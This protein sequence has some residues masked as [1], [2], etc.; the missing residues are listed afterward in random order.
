MKK[1]FLIT[2]LIS[3][4]LVTTACTY[5]FADPFPA[6]KYDLVSVTN[7][8]SEPGLSVVLEEKLRLAGGFSPGSDARLYVTATRFTQQVETVSSTG[9]PVRQKLTLDVA[10]EVEGSH[11]SEAVFGNETVRELYPYTADP[12]SLE[13]NRNAAV[14]LL[15]QAAA[16]LVIRRLEGAP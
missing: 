5:R 15:A 1:Q 3:A 7:S 12:A 11:R 8:T 9:T 4:L 16:E 2:C 10:W 6:S 14:R 13:W